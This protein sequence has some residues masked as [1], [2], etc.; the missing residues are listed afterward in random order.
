VNH[1]LSHKGQLF[2]YLKLQGREV[3]TMHLWGVG[4][5]EERDAM[6]N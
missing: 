1:L 3:N 4:L 6:S 5:A 2:Y